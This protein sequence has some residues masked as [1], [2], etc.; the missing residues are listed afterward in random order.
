MKWGGTWHPADCPWWRKQLSP[1][2]PMS[3]SVE[4]YHCPHF[5]FRVIAWRLTY[6]DMSNLRTLSRYISRSF[7]T[8]RAGMESSD[9]SQRFV[10]AGHS[11]LYAKYRASHSKGF[12]KFM[13]EHLRQKVTCHFVL[14][15]KATS[16]IWQPRLSFCFDCA[17]IWWRLFLTLASGTEQFGTGCRM[18]NRKQYSPPGRVFWSRGWLRHQRYTSSW[19]KQGCQQPIQYFFQVGSLDLAIFLGKPRFPHESNAFI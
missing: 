1:P 2:P 12:F 9:Y 4:R 18:W 10:S 3:S 16:F 17:L 15:D 13:V 14:P 19:S 6:T 8:Q 7:W 11:E 5:M